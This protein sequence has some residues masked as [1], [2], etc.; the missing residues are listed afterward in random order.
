M[1]PVIEMLL[2]GAGASVEAKVPAAYGLTGKIVD[3]FRS[4]PDLERYAQVVSFVIGGLLFDKGIHGQDALKCGINVEEFFNAVE[5]LANR[6]TLNATPF[7]GSWHAMI[8]EFDKIEPPRQD[9]ARI[10][11]IIY[12]GIAVQIKRALSSAVPAFK[13]RNIDSK[14]SDFVNKSIKNG[15]RTYHSSEVGVGKEVG[16][17]VNEV[18]KKW[19]DNLKAS[20][21]NGADFRAAFEKTID[22]KP[23]PGEG[24]IFREVVEK[25][26]G[27]LV[28][29]VFVDD[30]KRVTYLAPLG[31]LVRTQKR[32][33]V[34]SLNYDNCV[35]LF[36]ENSGIPCETG[37]GQWS[38]GEGFP[39][40]CDGVLLL[41]LHGSIDWET[42]D[43]ECEE[44][45]MP[46][47]TI[48]HASVEEMRAVDYWPA[49]IFGHRNKLTA[50]GPFLDLLRAFHQELTQ[51]DRLTVVGYSF[52]DPHINIFIS[53]WI[54][55]DPAHRLRIVNGERFGVEP[56]GYVLEL[57]THGKDRVEIVRKTAGDGL[58]DLFSQMSM[59][60][61]IDPS[62]IKEVSP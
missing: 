10:Q 30:P 48:Q 32:L 15:S 23:R 11:K 33:V 8:E 24:R 58:A 26:I 2:F 50:E 43:G 12:D 39:S 17:L 7:V 31:D 57:L 59:D 49:V 19:S 37:I 1:R 56:E 20:R 9:A 61:L 28:N 45:P 42:S 55:S 34:A 46:H 25:M 29:L 40:N 5:M 16:D 36:C 54:N 3:E 47:R 41:K 60:D 44:R 51:A 62:A 27:M 35:E 13:A 38:R 4:S 21:L 53:Q 6:S 22:H 52:A 14:L 18:L